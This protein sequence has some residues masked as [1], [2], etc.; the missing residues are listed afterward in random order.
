MQ[1]LGGWGG[2]ELQV[3]QQQR[4][5]QEDSASENCPQSA[6]RAKPQR[7]LQL[8]RGVAKELICKELPPRWRVQGCAQ[9]HLSRLLTDNNKEEGGLWGSSYRH[10]RMVI[11]R[12]LVS[13]WASSILLGWRVSE[14]YTSRDLEL[15]S[16]DLEPSSRDLEV[17]SRV[18]EIL[19]WVQEI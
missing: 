14:F 9:T 16:R 13:C 1:K 4:R 18:Y 10:M 8:R 7:T 6:L 3:Y 2:P 19:N 15:G 12:R 17:S 5:G 11:K